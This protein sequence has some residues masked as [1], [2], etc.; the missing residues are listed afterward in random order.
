MG[1][2]RPRAPFVVLV[3]ALLAVGLVG[4]LLINTSMQRRAFELTAMQEKAADLQTREQ[5]LT[6][7]VQGL[8]SPDRIASEA[9]RLGMVPN[10]SPAF[11]R[12]PSGEVSGHP[13]PALPGT[14]LPGLTGTGH[15]NDDPVG[16]DGDENDKPENKKPDNKKPDNNKPDNKKPD[17][18]QPDR[19]S[20][21]RGGRR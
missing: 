6:L 7:E 16:Q 9:A 8:S 10:A 17:D 21:R 18:N 1:A 19:G 13:S 15:E 11:L 4:L 2:R 20:D 5:A 3:V 12:L 14:N